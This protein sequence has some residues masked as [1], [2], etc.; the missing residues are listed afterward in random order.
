MPVFYNDDLEDIF[1]NLV[2][3]VEIAAPAAD[4]AQSTITAATSPI[5]ADGVST[6]IITVQL[7]D[8]N[9][10]DMTTGGETVTLDTDL[11]SLSVVTDVGDGTY[12]A[13]LTAGETNGTATITGTVN[14]EDIVDTA[15]VVMDIA[16]G[17]LIGSVALLNTLT[18]S[19]SLA[20][21]LTG[22][23]GLAN[24][25]TGTVVPIEEVT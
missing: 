22:T 24:T 7:V 2:N 23:V 3:D 5:Y 15:S 1:V 4:P 18:G 14:G 25:L 11:G 13:Q 8:T 16:L 20:N 21:T 9:G 10:D 6:S 19:I 12:T 17:E